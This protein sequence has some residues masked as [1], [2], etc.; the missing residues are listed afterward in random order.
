VSHREW[1]TLDAVAQI[2]HDEGYFLA[3]GEVRKA[4]KEIDRLRARVAELEDA[5]LPFARWPTHSISMVLG[6][7]FMIMVDNCDDQPT[8]GAFTR[9]RA[10]LPS[11]P[12][13]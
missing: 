3:W 12:R 1:S 7:A 13:I 5:L 4:A 8:L 11:L 6:G 9:A 10:L 2:L